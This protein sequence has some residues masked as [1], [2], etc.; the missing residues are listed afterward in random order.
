MLAAGSSTPQTR[1]VSVGQPLAAMT[2]IARRGQIPTKHHGRRR[3]VASRHPPTQHKTVQAVPTRA[4]RPSR[5]NEYALPKS[6]ANHFSLQC[7]GEN[8]PAAH[9]KRGEI[10]TL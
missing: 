1:K 8:L 7:T 2:T 9:W 6:G 4:A 10:Q 5:C 3:E